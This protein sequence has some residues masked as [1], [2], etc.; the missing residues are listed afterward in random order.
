IEQVCENRR[1]RSVANFLLQNISAQ[2]I[3][4]KYVYEKP[5]E[6][7]TGKDSDSPFMTPPLDETFKSMRFFQTSNTR[8]RSKKL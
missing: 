3:R 6:N 7:V 5:S 8:P 1:R 4:A 2:T